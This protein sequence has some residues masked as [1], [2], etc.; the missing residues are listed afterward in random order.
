[1]AGWIN[2]DAFEA[3]CVKLIMVVSCLFSEPNSYEKKAGIR[4]DGYQLG[5][6]FTLLRQILSESKFYRQAGLYGPDVGQPRYHRTDILAGWV[7]T[8]YMHWILKGTGKVLILI[9]NNEFLKMHK[10]NYRKIRSIYVVY[11]VK[12]SV[13][14]GLLVREI[15]SHG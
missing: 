2:I 13:L 11:A 9:Q 4:V 6:D 1:M 7:V 12:V 14:S 5:K 3:V 10:Y 15:K 8:T